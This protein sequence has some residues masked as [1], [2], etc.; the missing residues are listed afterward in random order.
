MARGGR[1][2][3]SYNEVFYYDPRKVSEFLDAMARGFV[4]S[5]LQIA[6]FAA[7][8]LLLVTAMVLAYRLQRGR[9]RRAQARRAGAG[10]RRTLTLAAV[11]W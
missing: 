7:L 8:L 9:A 10:P 4:T 3:Y 11:P 2:V 5:P 1:T 6:L